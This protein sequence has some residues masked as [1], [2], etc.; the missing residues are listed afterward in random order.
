MM[1]YD[2]NVCQVYIMI[3]SYALHVSCTLNLKI[4]SPCFEI[5]L[6]SME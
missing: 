4:S 5:R 6:A 2:E 3:P 1:K